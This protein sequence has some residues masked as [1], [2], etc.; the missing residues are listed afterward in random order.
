[1]ASRS[2]PWTFSRFLMKTG[3]S[4]AWAQA[5]RD[6]SAAHA[7]WKRSSMRVCCGMLNVT[8]PTLWLESAGSLWRRAI[9]AMTA[10]ASVRLT[11]A[12]PRSKVPSTFRNTTWLV[13]SSADGK[14][15][16]RFS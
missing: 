15:S 1:M 16:M 12:P 6:G 3:S 10:S 8:T 14:V 2:S 5:S 4:P 7:C 9:S 11:R 13:R